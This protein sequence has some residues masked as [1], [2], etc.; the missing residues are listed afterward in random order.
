[1]KTGQLFAAGVRRDPRV[2][3]FLV[4]GLMG[5][6]FAPVLAVP[7]AL[8]TLVL[9]ARVT[10]LPLRW[11]PVIPFAFAAHHLTYWL[12]LVTGIASGRK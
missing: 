12:G 6:L 10:R 5:L 1:M 7:Y 4:A 9:G 11:W 2:T 8:V 3:A